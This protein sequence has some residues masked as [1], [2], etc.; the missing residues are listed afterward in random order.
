MTHHQHFTNMDA[1]YL[2]ALAETLGNS[3]AA[4]RV[5]TIA[6]NLQRMDERSTSAYSRG[7]TEGKDSINQHSNIR[8]K[9]GPADLS[10]ALTLWRGEVSILPQ[11]AKVSHKPTL[12]V[13]DLDL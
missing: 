5:L 11:V 9:D 3:E 6:S 13:D 4:V 12:T 10:E 8:P 7:Y 2:A 1:I